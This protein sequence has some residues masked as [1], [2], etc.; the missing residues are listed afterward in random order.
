M[1]K[2]K[3]SRRVALVGMAEMMRDRAREEGNA[4]IANASLSDLIASIE[5][6]IKRDTMRDLINRGKVN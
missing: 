2:T 5:E 1:S 6:V 4:T 3:M